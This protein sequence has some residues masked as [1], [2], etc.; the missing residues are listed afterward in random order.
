[1]ID[2]PIEGQVVRAGEELVQ[3]AHIPL[4]FA[5]IVAGRQFLP[6]GQ[7]SVAKMPSPFPSGPALHVTVLGD[8]AINGFTQES[9]QIQTTIF[10]KWN[11]FDA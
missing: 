8:E 2:L 11:I 1:M 3:S 7:P 6:G 4:D 9:G 5:M 10:F